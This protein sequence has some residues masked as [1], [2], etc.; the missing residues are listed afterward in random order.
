MPITYK[1]KLRYYQ[2]ALKEGTIDELVDPMEYT[3]VVEDYLTSNPIPE[4]TNDAENITPYEGE[5]DYSLSPEELREQFMQIEDATLSEIAAGFDST[6]YP[7]DVVNR[8]TE[9]GG[10]IGFAAKVDRYE[11]AQDS[12]RQPVYLRYL[13]GVD[14]PEII[15]KEEFDTKKGFNMLPN[16]L[17]DQ[18]KEIVI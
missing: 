3:T 15:S 9:G 14:K 7:F 6:K 1:E 8:Q 5:I 12:F 11:L 13:T 10:S 16:S 4:L 17:K 2:E 18:Y